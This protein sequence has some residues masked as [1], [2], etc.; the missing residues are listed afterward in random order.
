MELR[1]IRNF[2]IHSI[3]PGVVDTNMQTKIRAASPLKF[4]SSQRFQDLKTNNELATPASVANK[5]MSLIKAPQSIVNTT[6]S[7]SEI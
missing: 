4:K 3:A 7:L 5:L 6:L 2:Y 1:D